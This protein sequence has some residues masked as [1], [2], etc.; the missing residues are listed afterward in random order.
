MSD[1]KVLVW[2]A[3]CSCVQHWGGI[4]FPL[5]IYSKRLSTTSCFTKIG[6]LEKNVV[7]QNNHLCS[8]WELEKYRRY[9]NVGVYYAICGESPMQEEVRLKIFPNKEMINGILRR[10]WGPQMCFDWKSEAK[11]HV[12]NPYR[13]KLKMFIFSRK[14][15]EWAPLRYP[16]QTRK[17]FT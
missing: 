3:L 13:E 7:Y 15:G 12:I 14:R 5:G 11:G 1:D 10:F 9:K 17:W 4:H 8:A 16:H 2:A 6:G